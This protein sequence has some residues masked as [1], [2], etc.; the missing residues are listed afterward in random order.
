MEK[1][2][3]YAGTASALMNA[4]TTGMGAFASYV[5]GLLLTHFQG[6]PAVIMSGQM[7]IFCGIALMIFATTILQRPAD[8]AHSALP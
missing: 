3:D 7:A 2:G 5:E 6:V 8:L 1:A 4:L